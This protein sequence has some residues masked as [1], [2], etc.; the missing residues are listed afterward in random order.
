MPP[1]ALAPTLFTRQFA[2]FVAVGLTAAIL[3]W[4]ARYALSRWLP[5]WLAV[6]LAY[7][8]GM[9][10]AFALNRVLVFPGS[11]RRM[12]LQVRDFVIINLAFFPVVWGISLVLA[13]FVLPWLGVAA[14]RE[15]V[16]HAVAIAIPVVATFLL[17]KFVTFGKDRR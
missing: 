11:R 3:H 8:V 2:L 17:H 16:A 13:G 9:A 12:G 6:A 7:G 14:H 1:P 5:F 15:E 4:L 10:V